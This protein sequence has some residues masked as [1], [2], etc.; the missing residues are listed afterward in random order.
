MQHVYFSVSWSLG[1]VFEGSEQLLS[2][3]RRRGMRYV[4]WWIQCF[5]QLS[6]FWGGY[7][8]FRVLRQRGFIE[9][10]MAKFWGGSLGTSSFLDEPNLGQWYQCFV[11]LAVATFHK[12]VDSG[13]QSRSSRYYEFVRGLATNGGIRSEQLSVITNCSTSQFLE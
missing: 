13:R 5:G 6:Y 1:A 4:F 3:A 2:S 12:A 9:G 10:K 7:T 11:S 8:G